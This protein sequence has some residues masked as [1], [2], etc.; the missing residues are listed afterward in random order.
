MGVCGVLYVM[1]PVEFE[2]LIS[3]HQHVWSVYLKVKESYI[4]FEGGTVFIWYCH[5]YRPN[6]GILIECQTSVGC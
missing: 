1:V 4:S 5:S 2:V 3:L 6:S